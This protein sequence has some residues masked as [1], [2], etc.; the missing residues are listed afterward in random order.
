V[1]C[2]FGEI[3]ARWGIFWKPL[4]FSLNHSIQTIEAA[5]R[6][7]NFIVNHAIDN[8]LCST[9]DQT[10]HD[11]DCLQFLSA[12]PTETVGILGDDSNEFRRRRTLKKGKGNEVGRGGVL[13]EAL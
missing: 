3:D 10:I 1:E 13:D 7:H 8:G 6:L 11:E 2:A 9:I 5:L 12:N 4:K